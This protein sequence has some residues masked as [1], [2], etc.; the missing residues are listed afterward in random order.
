MDE[1]A[2]ILGY[3][4]IVLGAGG[5]LSFGIFLIGDAIQCGR[6]VFRVWRAART[7]DIVTMRWLFWVW[8]RYWIGIDQRPDCLVLNSNGETIYWPGKE[9]SCR[10]P[11]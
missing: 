2:K 10:Y 7:E 4:V 6:F 5:I 1:V 3:I 9:G 11:G 8:L